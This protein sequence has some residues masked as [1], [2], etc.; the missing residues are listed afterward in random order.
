MK[1]YLS[2]ASKELNRCCLWRDNLIKEGI[3]ITV[4]WM[5]EIEKNGFGDEFI[6]GKRRA[7]FAKND[8]NGVLDADVFW[9]LVP[10][11]QS[12]GAWVELGAALSKSIIIGG[13]DIITSGPWRSIFMD[14][15]D[16]K[17]VT[18]DD[19]FNYILSLRGKYDS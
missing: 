9:L 5:K 1:V 18:D 8:I 4:D 11:N 7:Q 13:I 6:P 16:M 14:L 2:G 19:A 17:F 3:D 15:A 10:N 12:L